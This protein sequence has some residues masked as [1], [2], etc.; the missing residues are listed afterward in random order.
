[1]EKHLTDQNGIKI[2]LSTKLMVSIILLECLLM[3]AIIFVVEKQMRA[4]ILDEFMKHGLSV[5]RN[6]AAINSN[7][8]TTYNYIN[9]KQNVERVVKDNGLLYAAVLFY[10][11]QVAAYS[12]R[13]DIKDGVL[14]GQLYQRTLGTGDIL[15]QHGTLESLEF[16]D[17][18]VPIIL[19]KE[20]WGTVRTGV[21]LKSINDSILRV[22]KHLLF[23]GGMALIFG[24][25]SSLILARSITRP[26]A[27]LVHSVDAVSS[28]DYE[29][30][31]QIQTRDEIGYLGK[32]FTTMQQVVKKHVNL[33]V[34]ANTNLSTANEKLKHEISERKQAENSLHH[35]DGIL[36]AMTYASER[37]LKDRLWHENIQEVL[38][39]LGRAT[40]VH[41]LYI[42]EFPSSGKTQEEDH[43][44]ISEWN[45]PAVIPEVSVL[46][47]QPPPSEDI[48][49]NPCGEGPGEQKVDPIRIEPTHETE[50]GTIPIYVGEKQWGVLGYKRC[51]INS[52][53]ST[54]AFDAIR[55]VAGY[56]GAAIQQKLI[57]ESLEDA[58]R[59]KDDFLANMSHELRTPLNHVIGFTELIVDKQFGDLNE[60]QEEYLKDVVHSS[61]HLL[62]LIND[63]LDISKIE[64]G[65]LSLELSV[66]DL[67][68]LIEN[69]IKVLQP[70][71]MK[72]DVRLDTDIG[73]IPASI[74]ADQR[75]LEQI[76]YNLLS[77]GL[78]F[79]P[80][81]GKVCLTTRQV[82]CHIRQ[83]R[84]SQDGNNRLIVAVSSE[85]PDDSD[86]TKGK[87]IKFSI[88][89]TGIGIEQEDHKRIF[90]SF[91]QV[92]GSSSR[93]YGGAGLG[94]S[95][96]QRLVELH[97]GRIWVDSK[98]TGKGSTFSFVIP[99]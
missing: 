23:L 25:L 41:R 97:G 11:G 19:K 69:S 85:T 65:R 55:T 58:N 52:A 62:S 14:A 6:L 93:Q 99:V 79:T 81:G 94:L 50:H 10:D 33:L 45:A 22:R 8:V 15:V 95:L 49:S 42:S 61:R 84:R 89:D 83:A 43:T 71:S 12:G 1:M 47:D 7:F 37:F 57:L 63:I 70:E 56:L 60:T 82:Y 17:I 46:N 77:N 18:A 54:A 28:G 92:D 67:K 27:K 87:A 72:Q 86:T 76:L 21:S 59:L 68:S 20:N 26:V 39:R 2:K 51:N 35:R 64:T 30:P 40:N 13:K 78:K 9:I 90:D 29:H 24:C 91:E 4:S 38:D 98:G 80:E 31:I 75:K 48:Q 44:F 16:Y 36:E 74:T 3:S 73:D 53:S 32:R 5:T 66:V 88:S 96:A 34:E